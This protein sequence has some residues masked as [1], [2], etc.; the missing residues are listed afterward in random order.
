MFKKCF[1][2]IYTGIFK[3]TKHEFVND[4][5][6]KESA[7]DIQFIENYTNFFVRFNGIWNQR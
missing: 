2:V 5:S 4:K 6:G 1:R 7:F 3:F